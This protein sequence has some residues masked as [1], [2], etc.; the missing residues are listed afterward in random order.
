VPIC[1]SALFGILI[2]DVEDAVNRILPPLDTLEAGGGGGGRPN[3][4]EPSILARNGILYI[5][6]GF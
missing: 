1:T 2:P 5:E 3:P 4:E 6:F